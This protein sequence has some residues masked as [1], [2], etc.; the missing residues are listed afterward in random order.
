MDP[1]HTRRGTAQA[2]HAQ[3]FTP[4][5]IAIEMGIKTETVRRYLIPERSDIARYRTHRDNRIVRASRKS[6]KVLVYD[7]PDYIEDMIQYKDK[8]G[9]IRW[10]DPV[11]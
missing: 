11:E 10:K 8:N 2:M 1:I 4:W 6:G 3:G 5:E 9:I 7:E